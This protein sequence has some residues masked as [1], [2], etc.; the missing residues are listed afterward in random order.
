MDLFADLPQLHEIA[1]SPVYFSKISRDVGH[2]NTERF[3][4]A[5]MPDDCSRTVARSDPMPGLRTRAGALQA[6]QHR[7]VGTDVATCSV[8]EELS[9][10]SCKGPSVLRAARQLGKRTRRTTRNIASI[11]NLRCP[12]KLPL[13][14][15]RRGLHRRPFHRRD[16]G[17][18][19]HAKAGLAADA[20]MRFSRCLWYQPDNND[21]LQPLELK[22][23][24]DGACSEGLLS[25]YWSNTR[26]NER[27]LLSDRVLAVR[28]A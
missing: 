27:R 5:Q 11:A 9:Q 26:A 10:S 3:P 19:L 20:R 17:K 2:W 14:R 25:K 13:V 22:L 6:S 18:W 1:H 24:A 16:V 21:F 23:S 4:S 8:H 28:A 12:C 15:V 7:D